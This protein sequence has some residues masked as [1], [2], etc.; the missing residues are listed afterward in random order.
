[1]T[2]DV[3]KESAVELVLPEELDVRHQARYSQ[4][5]GT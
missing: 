1:M 2:G 3:L 4:N 5:V